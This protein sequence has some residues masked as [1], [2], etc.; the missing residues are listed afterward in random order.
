MVSLLAFRT[1]VCSI[2]HIVG[3]GQKQHGSAST[4][5]AYFVFHT[6]LLEFNYGHIIAEA[7]PHHRMLA[8]AGEV[9]NSAIDVLEQF[10]RGDHSI[11]IFIG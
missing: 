4:F 9:G 6:E 3:L 2:H 7:A 10:A 11:A 8:V 5:G 1:F